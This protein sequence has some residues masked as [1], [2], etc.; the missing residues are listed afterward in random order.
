M[1]FP[2]IVYG[3]SMEPTFRSGDVIIYQP[4]KENQPKHVHPGDIVLYDSMGFNK[5]GHPNH[6]PG[7][8]VH[9]IIDI[10]C[11]NVSGRS[12]I[13]YL[14]KGDNRDYTE[15]IRFKEIR[16]RVTSAYHLFTR[17]NLGRLK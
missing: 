2:A 12:E 5:D 17:I 13:F 14:I 4:Y 3:D 10:T 9:R 11:V 15:H 1:R 7:I 16:G 8:Y 6:K